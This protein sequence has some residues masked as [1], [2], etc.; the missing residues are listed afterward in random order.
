M[1]P[2][3]VLEGK[4]NDGDLALL[5]QRSRYLLDVLLAED[6]G[7]GAGAWRLLLM[8]DTGQML[9]SDAKAQAG[10]G[11]SRMGPRHYLTAGVSGLGAKE[12]S[13]ALVRLA[14]GAFESAEEETAVRRALLEYCGRDTLAL[15][16]VHRVL[17]GLRLDR[18]RTRQRRRR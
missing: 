15:L 12:A 8:E 10:Q 11:L 9:A 5:S 18:G 4:V 1:S 16:E 13:T 7:L 2:N 6:S 14:L 3:L 17:R